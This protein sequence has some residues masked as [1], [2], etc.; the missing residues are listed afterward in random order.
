MFGIGGC[1]EV[2]SSIFWAQGH[3]KRE[4]HQMKGCVAEQRVSDWQMNAWTLRARDIV[5]AR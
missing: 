2:W 3:G 5:R 4:H 1:E